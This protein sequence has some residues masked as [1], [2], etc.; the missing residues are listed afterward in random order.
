[1]LRKT[2]LVWL[3]MLTAC[4]SAGTAPSDS[5]PCTP[6]GHAYTNTSGE[7]AACCAGLTPLFGGIEFMSQCLQDCA[8]SGLPVGDCEASCVPG[9]EPLCHVVTTLPGTLCTK[10]GD[11]IC[12]ALETFC[13]CPKDCPVPDG[14]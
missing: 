12:G 1:M 5:T 8:G 6:E 10:C 14:G 13:N 7:S 2:T 4:N 3:L 11:G 9:T